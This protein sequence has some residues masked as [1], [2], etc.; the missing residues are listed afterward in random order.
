MTA[1]KPREPGS[2]PDA[3]TIISAA[4]TV[5]GAGEVIDTGPGRVYAAS[6]PDQLNYSPFNLVQAV[7]LDV[8]YRMRTGHDGPI[9]RA[10]QRQYDELTAD[11]DDIAVEPLEIL[12][13]V[14]SESNDIVQAI[15]RSAKPDGELGS[16]V[17]PREALEILREIDE[18]MITLETARHA[19]TKAAGVSP[20]IRPSG[21]ANLIDRRAS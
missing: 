10:Y 5:K 9:L 20:N 1:V 2:F 14:T 12:A 7:K 8:A 18:A 6:D 21:V 19:Y 13:S 15:I 3:I 17:S 4:L 11:A 16:D